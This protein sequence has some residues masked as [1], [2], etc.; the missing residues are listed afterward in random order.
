[1]I[2]RSQRFA[3][4]FGTSLL[5]AGCTG[6]EAP[7]A[8]GPQL[9]APTG[10]PSVP[11]TPEPTARVAVTAPS[12]TTT[13]LPVPT[14]TTVPVTLRQLTSGGCCVQPFFSPDSQEIRFIDKPSPAAPA[15][16]YGVSLDGPIGEPQLITEKVAF[17]SPGGSI[18]VQAE[19]DLTR[20]TDEATGDTWSVDTGGA[21]PRFSPAGDR[22][23]WSVTDRDGPFDERR[24]DLF[25]AN[26]DGSDLIQIGSRVSARIY[27]WMPDGERLL[28]TRRDGDPG[29]DST[30]FIYTIASGE[31]VDLLTASRIRT[32]SMS[33]AGEWLMY[34]ST[35]PEDDPD[36]AGLWL[37]RTDG[38]GRTRVK[39]PSFGAFR[40]RS[41]DSLLYVPA[42]QPGQS[43]MQLWMIDAESGGA[44][45]MTDPELLQFSIANG[46][47]TVSPDGRYVAFVGSGDYN[48]WLLTLPPPARASS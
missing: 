31:R 45:P 16:I 1:M 25:V 21:T 9:P 35:F 48:I 32:I 46:D 39:T 44:E 28:M 23:L 3:L 22:I 20:F 30:L 26:L 5:W 40:W 19:G 8:A 12:P 2:G 18:V 13:A 14:P 37:V 7:S 42:R 4:L 11:A 43:S 29:S 6:A 41:A 24:S 15:G 27:G 38:T 36:E 17:S 34:F 33:P 10:A 47:W